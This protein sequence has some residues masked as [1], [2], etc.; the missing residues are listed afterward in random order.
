MVLTN[1][2]RRPLPEQQ[3]QK[4]PQGL[5]GD[6]VSKASTPSARHRL[7]S[8]V[9]GRGI[10]ASPSTTAAAAAAAAGAAA[11]ATGGRDTGGGGEV[12]T[13]RGDKHLDT[14]AAAT[15][16]PMPS[17]SSPPSFPE[18]PLRTAPLS[19]S[20][21]PSSSSSSSSGSSSLSPP[22]PPLATSSRRPADAF[23]VGGGD[24]DW[25]DETALRAAMATAYQT[26]G[27]VHG[28]VLAA[29]DAQTTSV[30]TMDVTLTPP[31][32]GGNDFGAGGGGGG[33]SDVTGGAGD[34][35]V[36]MSGLEVLRRL[37]SARKRLRKAERAAGEAPLSPLAEIADPSVFSEKAAG[38]E[39]GFV[40][41]GT[42][43]GAPAA[44]RELLESRV[45]RGEAE[46]AALLRASP[47]ETLRES[48]ESF[49]SVYFPGAGLAE[50]HFFLDMGYP[51]SLPVD[52]Y[53]RQ[54][55]VR[56]QRRVR[57]RIRSLLQESGG[58]IDVDVD[59]ALTLAGGALFLACMD[60]TATRQEGRSNGGVEEQ[61]TKDEPGAGDAEGGGGGGGGSVTAAGVEHK[62][63]SG[64]DA[65]E[66]VGPKATAPEITTGLEGETRGAPTQQQHRRRRHDDDD[67][68]AL[69]SGGEA[70]LLV[71]YLCAA[72]S[73]RVKERRR[74]ERSVAAAIAPSS[75][76]ERAG[77]SGGIEDLQSSAVWIAGRSVG[78]SSH[79]GDLGYSSTAAKAGA[80][81]A[82]VSRGILR[83]DGSV[84]SCSGDSSSSSSL[85]YTGDDALVGEDR[86]IWAPQLDWD[87]HQ[88]ARELPCAGQESTTGRR[89]Q[90]RNSSRGRDSAQQ[91]TAPVVPLA[92]GQAAR[93][94]KHRRPRQVVAYVRGGLCAL[95][96]V[97]ERDT[98]TGGAAEETEGGAGDEEG[99]A[100]EKVSADDVV[101]AT[102]SSAAGSE[103][104][105]R[106]AEY[107]GGTTGLSGVD[108]ADE[109]D[110][111]ACGGGGD[112]RGWSQ[113]ALLSLGRAIETSLSEDPDLTVLEDDVGDFYVQ[114]VAA[115]ANSSVDSRPAGLT[116]GHGQQHLRQQRQQQRRP[117]KPG[118]VQAVYHQSRPLSCFSGT[119]LVHFPPAATAVGG[120]TKAAAG[121]GG[122]D[123][124]AA[125]SGG[126]RDATPVL[127][128]SRIGD[129]SRRPGSGSP[130]S[131]LL[132]GGIAGGGNISDDGC[133]CDALVEAFGRRG[134]PDLGVEQMRRGSGGWSTVAAFD[135]VHARF[136]RQPA[137]V[138]G[139]G[140]RGGV[141][142][143]A[144]PSFRARELGIRTSMPKG[145]RWVIG[146]RCSG[147]GQRFGRD[148]GNGGGGGSS[149]DEVYVSIEA[150][151]LSVGDVRTVARKAFLGI[152]GHAVAA[153]TVASMDAGGVSV[154]SGVVGAGR[155][156]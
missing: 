99:A 89:E 148:G 112:G 132:I 129:A 46:V 63:E 26:L 113:R 79:A 33:P 153:P 115:G 10:G 128:S 134:R 140:H 20:T 21:A 109:L 101:H 147:A 118:P 102:G 40:R 52:G 91:A 105:E 126:D 30:S 28:P 146:Q 69:L 125:V 93:Y 85:P 77:P 53:R 141:G 37:A 7:R 62:E 43:G 31:R 154:S 124:Q 111:E 73:A 75:L 155:R 76:S 47:A 59:V 65:P 68:A 88:R 2:R 142:G 152:A 100:V 58:G 78:L 144:P 71:D 143:V 72:A 137:A 24:D 8:A 131:G 156:R 42:G 66:V 114:S 80:S 94:G 64:G 84:A 5:R 3:G 103:G 6:G 136:K 38:G 92:N 123:G 19:S 36:T 15:D 70:L 120:L 34:A 11:G 61:R 121:G 150:P 122:A 110:E 9:F 12:D 74:M 108:K 133:G 104:K 51:Q 130:C 95:V 29:L 39:R 97:R 149:G 56:I 117:S 127:P 23:G 49:F 90:D 83:R 18:G 57:G 35:A 4:E 151:V 50:P 54:L 135:D 82:A 25:V 32:V 45:R 138:K 48:L 22:P 41:N 60:Q 1:R 96:A 86:E 145:N 17:S 107:A 13:T 119:G 16:A 98:Y 14:A 139:E 27:L 116:N 87:G 67:G 106:R 55:G 81:T 44:H